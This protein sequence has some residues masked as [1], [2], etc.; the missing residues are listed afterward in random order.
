MLHPLEQDA[1][2]LNAW[3]Q[4]WL[5]LLRGHLLDLDGEREAAITHYEQVLAASKSRFG[6]SRTG[7]LAQRGL[8]APF[9]LGASVAS[10]P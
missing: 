9:R 10:A 8:E 2:L 1:N 7:K 4:R 5:L 3:S 6:I